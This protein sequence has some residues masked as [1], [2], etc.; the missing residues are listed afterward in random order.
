[1]ESFRLAGGYLGGIAAVNYHV[2]KHS[3]TASGTYGDEADHNSLT[4]TGDLYVGGIAGVNREGAEIKACAVR[5][6]ILRN[7]EKS[8]SGFMGGIA[9]QNDGTIEVCQ[10]GVPFDARV[11]GHGGSDYELSSDAGGYVQ[12]GMAAGDTLL[13]GEDATIGYSVAH[14]I[15]CHRCGYGRS[16]RRKPV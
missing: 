5:K 4:L 13:D 6:L 15:Q 10:V 12:E 1:M 7:Q 11:G 3:E 16:G 9:A 14:G 2:I 8:T